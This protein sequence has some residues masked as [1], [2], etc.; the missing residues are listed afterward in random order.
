MNPTVSI[1]GGISWLGMDSCRDDICAG[2]ALALIASHH[3]PFGE[4][5]FVGGDHQTASAIA[6]CGTVPDWTCHVDR[7]AYQPKGRWSH[8][9]I[10]SLSSN[11]ALGTEERELTWVKAG[12]RCTCL[13]QPCGKFV[14]TDCHS[15]PISLQPG[16]AIRFVYD[17]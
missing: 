1:D 3:L 5:H 12:T 7:A 15:G 11:L 13:D 16:R 6:F 17:I 9:K 2:Y 14:W 8:L 4:V 10:M